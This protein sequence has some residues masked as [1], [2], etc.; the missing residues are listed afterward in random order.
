MSPTGSTDAPVT[1]T[2][3]TP[4]L[5]VSVDDVLVYLKD[6]GIYIGDTPDALECNQI[7]DA[8]YSFTLSTEQEI[9]Q[10]RFANAA[11]TFDTA[12]GPGARNIEL[13][14]TWAKTADTVG[15]GSESDHWMSDEAVNR[16]IRIIATS[17]VLAQT[18]GTFYKRTLRCRCATTP[19]R[20]ANRWQHDGH[21][22]AHAFYDPRTWSIVLPIDR[23]HPDRGRTRRA[24][25]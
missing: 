25:T 21:S 5:A 13:E 6:G 2:V 4:G 16:Y 17:T 11:Q 8:L 18:P 15:T 1:G 23:Q 10:K 20:K 14:A 9:D 7:I 19:A 3:P 24:G 22:N 12:Y